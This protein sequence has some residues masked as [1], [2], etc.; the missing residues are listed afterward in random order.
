[1][2]RLLSPLF[3]IIQNRISLTPFM[4]RTIRWPEWSLI[5]P[6]TPILACPFETPL[7]PF[8]YQWL[9]CI[10]PIFI[11]ANRF[12][13]CPIPHRFVWVS[14]RGLD[15][16]GILWH[17]IT[18]YHV[19]HL[20]IPNPMSMS[21][22]FDRA[23]EKTRAVVSH[24]GHI[25]N[26]RGVTGIQSRGHGF[27]PD[28][29]T[30]HTLGHS[31]VQRIINRWISY[32]FKQWSPSYSVMTACVDLF[33][34]AICPKQ[35]VSKMWLQRR[36]LGNQKDMVEWTLMDFGYFMLEWLSDYHRH[37]YD[38]L[39]RITQSLNERAINMVT[40]YDHRYLSQ[41]A[42]PV[43]LHAAG[44]ANWLD[45]MVPNI[46]TQFDEVFSTLH[47]I[48]FNHQGG[49]MDRCIEQINRA[50]RILYECDNAGEVILD[51]MVISALINS[52]KTVTL[53]LKNGC[54]LN[55]ATYHDG[56][57]IINNVPYFSILKKALQC[58]QLQLITPNA[59]PALGKYLPLVTPEYRDAYEMNDLIILKGQANLQTMP[60][61]FYG[62]FNRRYTYRCPII[63]GLVVKSSIAQQCLRAAGIHERLNAVVF[64]LI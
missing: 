51:L 1:M 57:D 45:V 17:S 5:R 44:Y 6:D 2:R 24:R 23:L 21:H 33:Y 36:I 28:Y 60:R 55:D 3:N 54:I 30:I 42:L 43:L 40:H 34:Q 32:R 31:R 29:F 47:T 58:R 41:D 59:Y 39:K 16:E 7:N 46:D 50:T 12:V 56:M 9:R 10:C 20:Q 52:G 4:R 35:T 22:C 14:W 25:G 18:L 26:D 63:V 27:I 53:V 15:G 62:V 8:R 49:R 38:D 13:T 19:T 64:D 11:D 37:E 48:L 61:M